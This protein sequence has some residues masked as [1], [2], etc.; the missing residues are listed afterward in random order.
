V[1]CCHCQDAEKLFD[2]K[3]AK[4]DLRNYLKKGPS[5]ATQL[6]LEALKAQGVKDLTLLD[7][8][9][10]V[11]AI[12]HEL[13]KAG[14]SRGTAVE[15]SA[16]YLDAA[17]GE[18]RRQGREERVSYTYG[19]FVELAPDVAEADIVTLDKVICCYPHMKE[20]VGLSSGR[21]RKFYGVI[22]PRDT[23]WTR[24][25]FAIGNLF[26]SLRHS[27]FRV[28]IHATDAVDDVVRANGLKPHYQQNKGLWQVV[29][30]VR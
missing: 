5:G 6:L 24:V 14:A 7:I 16:A 12:Q 29:L 10:G 3:M 26:F 8:G 27:D 18:A 1:D 2:E 21:A 4:R 17:R 20:L 30:Y 22:Y 23:W 11:G 25:G 28:Y 19:D 15:A 13:L 9:G